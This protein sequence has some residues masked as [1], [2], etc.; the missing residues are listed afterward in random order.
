MGYISGQRY[1]H[2]NFF[3]LIKALQ[4]AKPLIFTSEDFYKKYGLY[5][6]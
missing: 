6:L 5:S 4:A 2:Q 1:F 3:C